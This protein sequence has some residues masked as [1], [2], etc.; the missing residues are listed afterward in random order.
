[1]SRLN[2]VV[3]FVENKRSIKPWYSHSAQVSYG[4]T[5]PFDARV[6]LGVSNLFDKAPPFS[7]A[8]FNDSFDGRT[9]DLAGRYW[10]LRLS[11]AIE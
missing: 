10:Y 8:A 5:L 11:G 6:T 9:Y 2:E 4:G 1:M 3:P 7:A